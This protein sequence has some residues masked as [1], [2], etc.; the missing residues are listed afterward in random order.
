MPIYQAGEGSKAFLVFKISPFLGD[1]FSMG[2]GFPWGLVFQK[3]PV[4]SPFSG[5]VRPHGGPRLPILPVTIADAICWGWAALAPVSFQ[6]CDVQE[7]Y[8][9]KGSGEGSFST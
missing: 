7:R 3:K 1:R 8:T 2:P 4:L 5:L 6:A 9:P